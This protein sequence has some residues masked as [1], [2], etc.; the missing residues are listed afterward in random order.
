MSMTGTSTCAATPKR[1][2]C[3]GISR[4]R[5]DDAGDV[6][7]IDCAGLQLPYVNDACA[8]RLYCYAGGGGSAAGL[9]ATVLDTARDRLRRNRGLQRRGGLV[10][11]VRHP[12]PHGAAGARAG[13]KA[14]PPTGLALSVRANYLATVND[15]AEPVQKTADKTMKVTYIL[16]RTAGA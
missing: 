14:P 2:G 13:T 10:Q 1:T 5:L 3:T 11:A 15:L 12:R 16:R 4:S 7:E 8:G 9:T 6:T